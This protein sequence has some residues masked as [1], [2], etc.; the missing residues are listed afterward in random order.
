M[1]NELCCQDRL[2]LWILNVFIVRKVSGICFFCVT[3]YRPQNVKGV[4]LLKGCY[5][6]PLWHRPNI[7]CYSYLFIVS[8]F[9]FFI[10]Q[11][12]KSPY[13]FLR[14]IISPLNFF[15][16]VTSKAMPL[17]NFTYRNLNIIFIFH[18]VSDF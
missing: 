6:V 11:C 15:F 18:F 7:F 13:L 10:L 8:F 2:I 4:L 3:I 1:D 12:F 5:N 17:K 16:P 14:K 9:L